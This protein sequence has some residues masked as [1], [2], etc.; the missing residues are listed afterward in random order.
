MKFALAGRFLSR[1]PRT[2]SIGRGFIENRR[3]SVAIEFAMIAV[4]LIGL[5]T[6]ILETGV[7]FIQAQQL[8]VA[9]RNA[10]RALR[11]MQSGVNGLTYASFVQ[12]YFNK[13]MI[14]YANV[15]MK[16][17][18]LV[19]PAP[20]STTTDWTQLITQ[21]QTSIYQTPAAYAVTANQHIALPGVSSVVLLQI[22][23]PMNQIVAILA[24][25]TLAGS[26][27]GISNAS[28]AQS[29]NGQL[30][31]LLTANYVCQVEP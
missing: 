4:P 6:A 23:Y 10:G 19:P 2:A 29:V 20:G 8:Q 21:A 5:M 13:P 31:Y 12:T 14:T 11:T 7:V 30:I 24:G 1:R 26:G 22:A 28:G 27:A 3:G 15:Q 9:T 17:T 16:I 18:N 25:S